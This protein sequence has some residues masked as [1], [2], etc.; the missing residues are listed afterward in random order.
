MRCPGVYPSRLLLPLVS[1]SSEVVRPPVFLR[2]HPLGYSVL[3]CLACDHR[4][5]HR[6]EPGCPEPHQ[7]RLVQRLLAQHRQVSSARSLTRISDRNGLRVSF[8]A[9]ARQSKVGL[10]TGEQRLTGA[11]VGNLFLPSNPLSRPPYQPS[12]AGVC[13]HNLRIRAATSLTR[14]SQRV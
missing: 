14:F 9:R 5:L 13:G 12:G 6:A 2:V 1:F 10:H 4:H 7:C 8:S 11:R 3:V